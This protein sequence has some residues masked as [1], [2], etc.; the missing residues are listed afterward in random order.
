MSPLAD[1]F[2][3]WAVKLHECTGQDPRRIVVPRRAYEMLQAEA[4]E[5]ATVPT[6]DPVSGVGANG[7]VWL[8]ATEIVADTE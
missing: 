1:A 2:L 5:W 7:R 4:R 8:G 6:G 3:T